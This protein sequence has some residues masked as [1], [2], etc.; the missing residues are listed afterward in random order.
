MNSMPKEIQDRI[1]WK[2]RIHPGD[3]LEIK[4]IIHHPQPCEDCGQTVVNRRVKMSV[5]QSK[6]HAAHIKTHCTACKKYKNPVSG[7]FDCSL[8]EVITHFKR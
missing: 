5:S 6:T 3:N 1:I 7:K 2:K 8:Y 4:Q